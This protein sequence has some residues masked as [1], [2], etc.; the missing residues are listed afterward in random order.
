M[1]FG[2]YHLM[3]RSNLVPSYLLH[4]FPFSGSTH[5]CGDDDIAT[6]VKVIPIPFCLQ[7]LWQ[8][9]F[10][11]FSQEI[12]K[13]Y[14]FELCH[15]IC[16][17]VPFCFWLS[18]HCILL[19]QVWEKVFGVSIIGAANEEIYSP[20]QLAKQI[21]AMSRTVN[22]IGFIGLGAM[23]FGMATHL[24]SSNFC[25]LGYDVISYL[26]FLLHSTLKD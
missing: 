11:T 5:V 12:F 25:V 18:V 1:S 6:L 3:F 16:H 26:Q 13:K 15:F 4:A 21:T 9:V 7:N 20:E 23:G 24:L 2:L 14:C 10:E 22:R 19:V 8:K 17:E